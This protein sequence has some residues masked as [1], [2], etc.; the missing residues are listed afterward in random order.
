MTGVEGR[1]A[2][3]DARIGVIGLGYVG[4]PLSLAFVDAGFEVRGFDIDEER[5]QRLRTADSYV[6]DVSGA[7]L[8]VGLEA[9][10]TPGSDPETVADCDAYVLA[11]PT[12]VVD[13]EPM[14]GAVEA[15]AGTVAEQAGERETLVVVSSTVYPGATSEVIDPVVSADRPAGSTLFAMVPERLN[16]GGG[17]E[18]SEIPL[19]VGA[20]DPTARDAAATLFEAITETIP[21]DA[22]ETAELSKTLENTYRMVN[23]ALVNQLVALAE[24]LDADVWEAI[25][26]AG[27]KPFGF[28]AFE[29]GPGVGGH[30]IPID[31]QFLTWR[32]GELGT[33]LPF[34]E[35]AHEV[36][37]EM[38]DRVV[39][40]VTTALEARGVP[41]EDASV[42]AFGAAYK[43][44]VGDPRHAPAID[45][46][47][48]L[49]R[50]A[51]VTLVDPH[52]DPQEA[53]LPIVESVSDDALESADAVVLLVD[54][55]AFDLDRIGTKATFVYDAK[56]AMP[57]DAGATVVTLGQAATR[58]DDPIEAPTR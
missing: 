52:V 19:V 6:D 7:D 17:H 18:I 25:E 41:L 44:N 49:R 56:N 42:L 47:E 15:A 57:R 1:F 51:D 23:I 30:C 10:F 11:V 31:P 5:V 33:E 27:T 55:D 9:G 24:R 39:E 8:E 2:E 38:P 54:H 35:H 48:D 29:P 36:N 46:F 40:G 43:P 28:Q 50:Y 13:G 37:E 34:I 12:G 26:A 45:V 14:M 22:T 16:P 58:T 4:L 32:A 53:E 3:R 21:V 20:D